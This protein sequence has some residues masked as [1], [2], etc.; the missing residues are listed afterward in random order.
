MV[1]INVYPSKL[2]EMDYV[3]TDHAGKQ[4]RKVC[5]YRPAVRNTWYL[6]V[7]KWKCIF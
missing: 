3:E 4:H 2:V 5:S 7:K 1:G 6:Q